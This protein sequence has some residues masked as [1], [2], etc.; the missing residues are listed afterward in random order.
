MGERD[1]VSCP[2]SHSLIAA[3]P[4]FK[5]S[6]SAPKASV[7]EHCKPSLCQTQSLSH[8]SLQSVCIYITKE[9]ALETTALISSCYKR[10]NK[11]R[12]GI[13][14]I[15]PQSPRDRARAEARFLIKCSL[16][17]FVLPPNPLQLC[18]HACV[19]VC[20]WVCVG[21]HVFHDCVQGPPYS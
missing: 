1:E 14:R 16:S 7:T 5:H 10:G 19:C 21:A 4:E 6:L 9:D 13:D 3:E 2:R 17:A 12:E 15:F 11:D 18:V 20:V 8:L